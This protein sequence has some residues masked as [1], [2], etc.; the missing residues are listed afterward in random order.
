VKLDV[1][2]GRSGSG[3]TTKIMNEIVEKL[4]QNTDEN[5]ILFVP[6]QMTFQAEYEIA[7][8]VKG[9]TYSN[10]Q[11]FSFKRL[12]YRIFLEVGGANRTFINDT[13]I[14]MMLTKIMES[15]KEQL[16]I[17]NRVS[18][19]Y[20]FVSMIYEV[21]KEFKS[22]AITPNQI[23]QVYQAEDV[24]DT[25]K[26]K[27]HDFNIIFD[28]LI[29]LYGNTLFDQEDFYQELSLK[30]SESEYIK[31]SVIYVDGYHHLTEV[32]LNALM[33]LIQTAKQVTLLLTID[34][35]D[36]HDFTDPDHL[37]HLVYRMAR[38]IFDRCEENKIPIR[39]Y[40]ISKDKESP[41]FHSPE[42]AFL[43][44]HYEQKKNQYLNDVEHIHILECLSPKSE[45][46]QMAR[47]IYQQVLLGASYSDFVVF[48]NNENVYYP[49]IS[50]IFKL[51]HIPVFIDDKKAMLDHS[52]LN[53]IDAALE[54]VKTNYRHEAM[55]RAIK[56]EMFM[57]LE[58]NGVTIT[59]E[60]Y[61][62][63]VNQYRHQIDLLENYCLSHGINHNKW[64][65]EAFLVDMKKKLTDKTIKYEDDLKREKLLN[66]LKQQIMEP[67]ESF[68]ERFK[69]S[70]T[71]KGKVACIYEL[72]CDIQTNEKLALYE[73]VDQNKNSGIIGLNQA[74]KHKQVQNK[75]MDLFEQLVLVAGD[76]EVET[77][78]LIKI[79]QTGFKSMSFH[80]VPP[81]IEQVMVGNIKRSR[82]EMMGHFDDAK[83][84][85][86]KKA[87]VLGVNENEFPRVMSDTGLITNK[88][89]QTLLEQ[90]FEINPTI[91]QSFLD[92]NFIIYTVITAPSEDLYL[93]Y[94]L[95]TSDK[96]EAY[97]SSV[98]D[99]LLHQ[100][101]KLKVK[102]IYDFPEEMD[103]QLTYVTTPEVTTSNLLEAVNSL[104]KGYKVHDLW[105]A[106][107]AY[108]AGDDHLREKLIGVDYKNEPT[109]LTQ[110]DAKDLYGD[111]IQA[112]VS[113]IERF[114][115]C[116]YA[117]F[118]E[119][120]LS[121][122]ERDIQKIEVMDIGDLYH[123]T[124]K[125]LALY[126][127][128][129]NKEL[130]E[131]PFETIKQIVN[132]RVHEMAKKMQRDFFFD[133]KRNEYLLHK[134]KE[135]L[136]NS[137]EVMQYQSQHS[138][139][140]LLAVEEKFGMNAERLKIEEKELPNGFKVQLK[141]IIDRI[142][143]A[144]D[145]N[146]TYVRVIDY[147]SGSKEIDFSKIYHRLS[148][149]L[150]TYLDVVMQN[151]QNLL[152][153][154][155]SAAGVLYYH[156][157]NSHIKA[158]SEMTLAEIVE[159]H[160]EEYKMNGY[161]LSEESVSTL[162]DTKLENDKKSDIIPVTLT[163][164]GYHKTQAKVLTHEEMDDLR[165]YTRKAI[166][167]SV[168]EMTN[169]KIAIKPV[170][171]HNQVPCTYCDYKSICKFDH[172]LKENTYQEADKYSNK[173][174]VIERIKQELGGGD[175]E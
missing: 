75:V 118:V 7:K 57:P 107:Y 51:Y 151:T 34:R 5:I 171:Y 141:G 109:P 157:Y 119:R 144:K 71:V 25:L 74:K 117:Y 96:K 35:M 54:I 124:L 131:V 113:S 61:T 30:V 79:L 3:K 111:T 146:D 103:E 123:E 82:F 150:F 16:K 1:L 175:N 95:S 138:K 13:A 161:T 73:A 92:E 168:L 154:E 11:V 165:R 22:F 55:F 100:F 38:K 10:L 63:Y 134:I 56:T 120:G 77:S 132:E 80:I 104:R 46:H 53:F 2:T 65:V 69:Q 153:E 122:K 108:Y 37:F 97:K 156:I 33:S 24:D 59:E 110:E 62:Y 172:Q 174:E 43:E 140:R 49:L 105:H 160:Q 91:E 102:T 163:N 27:L 40:P 41:R 155:A 136:F 152:N 98:I 9:K 139:F 167:D 89:R 149:Q 83:T 137:I 23:S 21:I 114:N 170:K 85:G 126:M 50:N 47:E 60:N 112:S 121:L 125:E 70:P 32:E 15:K 173:D 127:L 76:Y 148:L 19:N 12:A 78:E 81:A 64:L 18:A 68:V 14:H 87:F 66:E 106:L 129:Q 8:R 86:V 17:Y 169:G 6:E 166:D 90:E 29:K 58:M 158:K 42:L 39:I 72:L 128:K 88:E 28:E 162:F 135:S 44:R 48:T 142:D 147:K 133:N 45:V 36:E 4:H 101:P 145:G 164:N 52:L 26:N 99:D 143:Y 84:L 159:K 130:H 94:T 20:N 31:K 116:P 93:S 115:A 67:L